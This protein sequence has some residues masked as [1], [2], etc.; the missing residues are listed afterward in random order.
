MH[1]INIVKN[2]L[3]VT[4]KIKDLGKLKYFLGLEIAQTCEGIHLCQKKYALKILDDAGMLGAK[5]TTT[6]KK[7][8]EYV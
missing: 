6:P 5:P 4:F 1:E 2:S 8:R 3:N 7:G